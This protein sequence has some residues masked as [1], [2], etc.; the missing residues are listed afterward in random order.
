MISKFKSI[1]FVRSTFLPMQWK[2]IPINCVTDTFPFIKGDSFICSDVRGQLTA[3]EII[4]PY[5]DTQLKGKLY[6][7]LTSNTIFNNDIFKLCY[8]LF[9][10]LYI[11]QRYAYLFNKALYPMRTISNLNK[12]ALIGNDVDAHSNHVQIDLTDC[13]NLKH[14]I[15]QNISLATL[16]LPIIKPNFRLEIVNAATD[17][18]LI[19]PNADVKAL[20]ERQLNSPI[21]KFAR[22]AVPLS[23]C[24]KVW[25]NHSP[26]P[27][28]KTGF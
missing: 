18:V 21:I 4:P 9:D 27:Y 11:N 8:W 25:L 28:M 5:V 1:A 16:R 12:V 6:L 15:L 13:H 19:A 23:S 22:S 3:S 24:I 10:E 2:N 20:L 26:P 14:L 7:D 17:V